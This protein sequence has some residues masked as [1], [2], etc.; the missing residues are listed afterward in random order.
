MSALAKDPY[1]RAAL[2]TMACA[3]AAA[4]G[5]VNSVSTENQGLQLSL[6]DDLP[7]LAQ[8]I[9]IIKFHVDYI[10]IY[11]VYMMMIDMYR[12]TDSCY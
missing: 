7:I 2:V 9:Q 4:S 11:Y 3:L 5:R 8:S 1:A 12:Y 10:M 6:I